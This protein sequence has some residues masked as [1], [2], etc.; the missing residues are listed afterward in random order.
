[1]GLDMYAKLKDKSG[2][3]VI[4]HDFF[5][6]RK[7]PDLR[8]W[9]ERLYRRKGGEEHF[10]CVEVEL[11]LEDINQLE[12][13]MKNNKLEKTTGFFF[14]K[15]SEHDIEDTYKFIESAKGALAEGNRVFYD[16]WW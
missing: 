12:E 2:E 3:E 11:T 13:D 8:G 6:W 7:H 4:D 14:G 5:Y 15:S 1:M 16:S 9:M 10:N